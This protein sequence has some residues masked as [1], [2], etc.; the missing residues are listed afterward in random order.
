MSKMF[1]TVLRAIQTRINRDFSVEPQIFLGG[2]YSEVARGPVQLL[3]S[4]RGGAFLFS[5][6]R[7]VGGRVLRLPALRN[8]FQLSG[9]RLIK[10]AV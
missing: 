1:S 5:E 8:L 6:A 3:A 4:E 7:T 9:A 2:R 10:E